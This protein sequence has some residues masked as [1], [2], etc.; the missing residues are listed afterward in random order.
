ME[1]LAHKCNNEVGIQSESSLDIRKLFPYGTQMA[2]VVLDHYVDW[3]SKENCR[4]IQIVRVGRIKLACTHRMSIL[5]SATVG[6][7]AP[8]IFHEPKTNS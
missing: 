8:F 6:R 7:D 5:G 4:A 3:N 1:R 2:G